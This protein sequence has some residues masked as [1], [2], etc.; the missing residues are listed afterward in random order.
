MAAQFKSKSLLERIMEK[1]KITE[2]GCIIWGG[3]KVGG[4]GRIRWKGKRIAVHRAAYEEL[5]G[6]IPDGLCACHMCDTPSCVN[7]NHI[8]L[9]TRADNNRDKTKKHRQ[10][11]GE[12]HAKNLYGRTNPKLTEQ[13][14]IEIRALYNQG[15]TQYRLAD[16]YHVSQPQINQIVNNK[17][18]SHLNGKPQ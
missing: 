2:G 8:F 17:S 4:Y 3:W 13:Q 7:P 1:S 14:V 9:G 12:A 15:L 18:W 6:P 16:M 5:N 10:S 11:R